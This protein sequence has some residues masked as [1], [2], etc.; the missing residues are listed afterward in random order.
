MLLFTHGFLISL[1]K[2]DTPLNI[3]FNANSER[4]NDRFVAFDGTI[5]AG[6]L[7]SIINDPAPK[8]EEAWNWGLM[9]RKLKHNTDVKV[10]CAYSY[11]SIAK[12]ESINICFSEATSVYRN[13]A[14]A[15][16]VFAIFVEKRE[17][18]LIIV[19]S[20]PEHRLA[21]VDAFRTCYVNSIQ[22]QA[23]NGLSDAI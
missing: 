12:V 23:D 22:L 9:C 20:K 18:P 2:F 15:E 17:E 11:A 3:L 7:K 21:L 8:K 19:C 1:V 5:D 4:L 16:L 13:S 14:W 6:E 10:E